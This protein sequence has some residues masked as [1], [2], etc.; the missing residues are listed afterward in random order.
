MIRAM[1]GAMTLFD[2]LDASRRGRRRPGARA[3]RASFTTCRRS[4]ARTPTASCSTARSTGS[5]RSAWISGARSGSG[6][7]VTSR[8]RRRAP[9][10]SSTTKRRRPS[11]VSSPSSGSSTG[12]SSS[13]TCSGRSA[14]GSTPCSATRRGRPCR[15]RANEFFSRHDP[16]YRTLRQDGGAR[17]PAAAVRRRSPGLESAGTRYDERASRRFTT[18]SRRAAIR[19]TSRSGAGSAAA[20]ARGCVGE[21]AQRRPNLAERDHRSGFRAPARSI[22]TRLFLEASH[23]LLRDGGRLGMLVP[24]GVYTDAGRPSSAGAP[25]RMLVGVVLLLREPAADLPDRL[26]LQVRPDRR[27]ARRQRPSDQGRVHAPRRARVGAAR[28]ARDRLSVD[29]IERFAPRLVVHGVEGR[30]RPRA[31]RSHLR[32]SRASRGLSSDRTEARIQQEFND[33][34][35]RHGSSSSRRSSRGI[36]L[37]TPDD[38]TARPS[39][40]ARFASRATCRSTKASRSGSTIRTS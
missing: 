27:G 4:F 21:S 6:R 31:R 14:P 20:R 40:R 17:R 13:P 35:A 24:S 30:P 39:R 23:H 26:E 18:A 11:S 7:R 29:D 3:L 36:G 5:S 22:R 33:E 32:R 15:P 8:S 2:G 34:H 12:R 16:L 10:P 37:S 38:D 28:R 1:G 19:S 9:G 25:R